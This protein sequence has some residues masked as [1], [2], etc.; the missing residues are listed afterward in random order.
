MSLSA[1]LYSSVDRDNRQVILG[2]IQRNETA[3]ILDLGCGSGDFTMEMAAKIGTSE[4]CG[5]ELLEEEAQKAERKS[6][7][8]YRADLNKK[9]P[10]EDESFDF[11]CANQVIEHLYETDLFIKEIYRV[12]KQ[13]GY[14]IISTNNLASYHNIASLLLGKQPFPSHVSNEVVVGLL[15]KSWCIEHK[16]KG[17]I[18]L[19]I[20]T[21]AGLKE[22][23]E[24]HRF[25]VEKMV[26]VGFYP[27][28]NRVARILSKIDGRHS[29]Y[30]T[31][32]VRK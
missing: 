5:I 14:A 11:V 22:L 25:K 29:V 12:L 10:I 2:M 23:F 4:I 9:F 16:N 15:L 30:L 31:M 21:P 24:Y 20:F 7:K 8:V 26:G 28:P 32:K 18:H 27:F 3:A 6:I 1:K 13:G 19:R 17:S